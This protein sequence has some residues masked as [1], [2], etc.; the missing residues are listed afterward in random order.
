MTAALSIRRATPADVDAIR[1]LVLRAYAKWVP[2][3]P[4]KPRPMT[5]DYAL[6]IADYR[7]D[8]LFCGEQL[9]GVIGTSVKEGEL[10][11]VNVAIA[12]DH[13]GKG[14]GTH[15]MRYAEELARKAGASSMR[16]LTNKLMRENVA[17]YEKLGFRIE[18]ET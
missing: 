4:R 17:L 11:I 14:L 15:L 10:R 3:T 12:P 9:A 6:A 16:L 5:T 1:D 18:T 13:Q 2:I 7:Y 8:L